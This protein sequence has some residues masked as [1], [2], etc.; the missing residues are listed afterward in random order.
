MK[1]I[2]IGVLALATLALPSFALAQFGPQPNTGYIDTWIIR[3]MDWTQRAVTFLM[4]IATLYFIWTVIQYIRVKE[5]KDAEERKKAM[6]RG[7]IGLAVM[8]GIW[9]IINIVSNVFG[10]GQGGSAPV[11]CPP[12]QTYINSQIGCR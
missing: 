3:I 9:G 6:I 4:V 5:A 10:V 1:K 8:V 12:G 11:P 7:I 2:L